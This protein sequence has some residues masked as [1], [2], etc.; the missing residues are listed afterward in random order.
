MKLL[1]I[2]G[3]ILLFNLANAQY[4]AGDFVNDLTFTDSDLDSA[5]AIIYSEKSVK[6]LI[7]SGKIIVLSFFNPG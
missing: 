7:S 6:G 5:S 2:L 4:I 3:I 1:N